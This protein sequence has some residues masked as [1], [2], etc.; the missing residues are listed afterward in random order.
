MLG[1]SG[2]GDVQVAQGQR[3]VHFG[4]FD[5]ITWVSMC[6]DRPEFTNIALD[7][8]YDENVVTT[9]KITWLTAKYFRANKKISHEEAE[10]LRAKGIDIEETQF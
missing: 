10:R 9:E 6:G 3:G 5:H 7:G 1:T 2:G 8:I 4:E